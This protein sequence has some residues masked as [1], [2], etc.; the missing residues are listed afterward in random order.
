MMRFVDMFLS[1]PSLL[2][3][4]FLAIDLHPITVLILILVIAFMRLAHSG[5]AHPRRDADLAH[6]RV[7]A[8]RPRDGRRRGRIV[9]R[10]IVPNTIGTIIVNATFQVADAI[11][12][13]A[14]LGFLGLGI[15]PPATNWGSMLSNGV[16]FVVDGYWWLIYP[17]GIASSWSSSRSTSSATASG[18]LGGAAAAALSASPVVYWAGSLR[19]RDHA[20]PA[21]PPARTS[22]DAGRSPAGSSAPGAVSATT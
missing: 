20:Q 17:A 22:R 3:V 21:G 4:L 11:L 10:H 13:L 1:I 14:A 6:P 8:G 12:L 9:L 7:R 19:L 2:P 16:N 5:P 15:P 18:C